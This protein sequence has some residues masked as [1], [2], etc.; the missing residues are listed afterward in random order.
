[1]P[2][3]SVEALKQFIGGLSDRAVLPE[4]AVLLNRFVAAND[5]EAFELLI[6]RHGP[7]VLGTARRLVDNADDA[8]D[9]FQA[10]FLSL[11]RLAKS[12]RH[13]RALSAW[14]H[15]TTFRI[16]AK[17]RKNRVFRLG[18]SLPE[19]YEKMDPDAQLVWH[20]V[21]KALDEE[22]HHLPER[23][24]SPLLLCYLSGLTRDEAAKQLGW[25]LGTLKRRLDEGRKAL[26]IRLAKRGIAPVG[27]ALTV[28]AP[29]ALQA[30]VS[31]SLFEST[32]NMIFSKETLAPA[33][34]SALVLS[35]ATT[36]RGLTMKSIL[37]I[38]AAIAV[39]VGIYAGIGN[40]DPP[41]NSDDKKADAKPAGGENVVQMED[42]VPAGVALR[43]GT[44]RFRYGSRIKA[45]SV[46]PDGKMALVANDG[47]LPCVF[48]L[49]TGRRLFSLNRGNIEVGT[50]SRDGRW[51]VLK[52][53]NEL[54][55][56]DAVTGKL[57]RT[58][59]GPRTDSWRDA[60]I[61]F[62]PDGKT[63]AMS[64]QAKF[65]H[66]I[67]FETG[68]TV[69]EFTVENLESGVPRD[70]PSVLDAAFSPDGKLLATGGYD[71][72]KGD[73]FARLWDVET[74]KEIRRFMH[75]KQGSGVRSLVFSPD[76]KTLATLGTQA[77]VLL[78]L[79]EVDTGKLL[80]AFP[81]D[82]GVR[83]DR[84]SVAFSPDGK[85][86]AA[87]SNSIRL[88]DTATGEERLRIDRRASDLH[89]TDN[90]KTLTAAVAGAI[91]RWDTA[92]GKTLTP[93]AADSSVASIFVT[94]DGSRVITCGQYG[95][96]HIWDGAN[97]Q[98]L[99]RFPV[100]RRG[101][102]AL[103]PDGR[104][105]AWPVRDES[106]QFTYPQTPNWIYDG[107]RIRLYDIAAD[108]FVDRFPAFKG[109]AHNLAF[110][111]DGKK[112]VTADGYG[113]WSQ[114]W[115]NDAAKVVTVD[116][117]G[118]RVRIW[119]FEAGKEER[120]FA[121][122][123]DALKKKSFRLG[124][125]QLS[126]AG[127]AV[128]VTYVEDTG[129]V[130]DL[131]KG[132]AGPPHETRVWDV[133][134]GKELPKFD[135]DN[136]AAFSPDGRFVVTRGNNSVWEMATGKRV[137]TLPDQSYIRAAD[138]SPDGR[139]LAIAVPEDLIQI[140]E[141]ATWTKRN[142]FKGNGDHWITLAFGPGERLYTG[143][144]DTTVLVW[145]TRPPHA[146]DSVSLE[147]AW[148]DLAT[149]EA[150]ASFQSEGRFLTAPAETVKLFA[151]KIKPAEPLRQ[152]RAVMI[153]EMI[154][155]GESKNLLKK[156]A[157]GPVGALLTMEASAALKRLEVVSNAHR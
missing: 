3:R 66:L 148:N 97:G 157:D 15:N 34:V 125:V 22:L 155:D 74:G 9:V 121:V 126:A 17:I 61:E 29:E 5:R 39:G 151:E 110:T 133:A 55:V 108:K 127:K 147:R 141:V 142:E 92:T 18:T 140:W 19:P 149:R 106:A 50:F 136:L 32:L 63:I 99:R 69:R 156:W 30:A 103:S 80:K 40:A 85:T 115:H 62:T 129:G 89:F 20:E 123:T 14:L 75:G 43:V 128:V 67:D 65:I 116:D 87:A 24:R 150:S 94:P 16:A 27:L 10:V 144:H 104:F 47:D 102:L 21:R 137:A 146:A 101:T 93:E 153:L 68:K 98:H 13:G 145:D 37:A 4:D 135:G 100:G 26:R 53:S 48:D 117:D 134:T 46:S 95:E 120:S 90:G 41:K 131:G 38:L 124:G 52:Q 78:R 71:N 23:L 11:A 130:H 86:V 45:L 112:L 154:G 113:G 122:V 118:G 59:K 33:A 119:D 7:M 114:T 56:F 143:H 91:Y 84:G 132:L 60:V 70:F 81:K 77:G 139:Y 25:S 2:I 73:Y 79:F 28:L 57:G 58:I 42:P 51:L 76:G 36:M 83:P 88:Y 152:I 49:A 105:L 64:T 138:F 111:S 35:S 44:S 107:S 54:C 72:D 6:I 31:Q 96:A 109:D 8:E 82:D 12:I 1:M